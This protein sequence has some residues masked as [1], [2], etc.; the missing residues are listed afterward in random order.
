MIRISIDS[1]DQRKEDENLPV[2]DFRSNEKMGIG[3]FNLKTRKWE[4]DSE[5]IEALQMLQAESD[6]Y[7]RAT[8]ERIANKNTSRSAVTGC[9]TESRNCL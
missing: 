8:R 2:S 6:A 9:G 1:P 7:E 3:N 5:Q 4:D